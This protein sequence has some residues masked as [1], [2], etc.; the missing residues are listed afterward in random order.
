MT[1]TA[2]AIPYWMHPAWSPLLSIRASALTIARWSPQFDVKAVLEWSRTQLVAMGMP[3]ARIDDSD[4]REIAA[5]VEFERK[6]PEQLVANRRMWA[7]E[8]L[9]DAQAPVD[10]MVSEAIG[11]EVSLTDEPAGKVAA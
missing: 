1:E 6:T 10:S 4:A 3:Q 8:I 9:R 7:A 11:R 5:Q 2:E